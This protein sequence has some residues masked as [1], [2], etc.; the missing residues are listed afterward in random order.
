MDV[1]EVE[2]KFDA[3]PGTPLPTLRSGTYGDSRDMDMRAVYYDTPDFA[4]FH[5]RKGT[6]R[7][8]EGGE[9][10]G[11]HIKLSVSGDERLE[12]HAPLGSPVVPDELRVRLAPLV[13]NAPLLPAATLSTH[14]AET[15]IVGPGGVLLGVVCHDDVTA[16]SGHTVQ[17]WSEMEV[18]A[19]SGDGAWL[20]SVAEDFA[21]AGIAPAS[22]QSKYAVAVTPSVNAPVPP[23][24][25]GSVVMEYLRAQV[26]AIEGFAP[27]VR[28]QEPDAVHRSRVATRRLRGVLRTFAPLFGPLPGLTRDLRWHAEELGAARDAEVLDQTLTAFV[29]ELPSEDIDGPVRERVTNS[30]ATTRDEAHADLVHS[31]SKPRY[32]NLRLALIGLLVNP[33]L[34]GRAGADPEVLREMVAAASKRTQ[35]A[36]R[37]AESHPDDLSAWHRVRKLAKATR[38]ACEAMGQHLGGDYVVAASAWEVVTDAL[39]RVQ[40]TQ[41]ARERLRELAHDAHRA[42]EPTRTY[43]LLAERERG[44]GERALVEARAALK[45]ALSE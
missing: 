44:A 3:A 15:D 4:L 17:R 45:A 10:Q 23:V 28:Q 29:G 22:H 39:G 42:G 6:L 27:G 36:V 33:P 12:V 40:D 31:M 7:R 21:A 9:D 32:E 19:V 18:E 14:R 24:T 26:G 20:E 8:R 41:V 13:G 25:A 2:R 11:W 38:Y 1:T 16:E 5:S 43:D 30:L 34:T 37:S 35:S